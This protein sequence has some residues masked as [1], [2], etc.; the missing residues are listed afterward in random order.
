MKIRIWRA[1]IEDKSQDLIERNFPE[2]L[3]TFDAI[4]MSIPGGAYTT[5]RTYDHKKVIRLD[6]H[7]GRLEE[8][9]RLTHKPVTL[10]QLRLREALRNVIDEYPGDMDL[11]IRVV[12]DLEVALGV[13]YLMVERLKTPPPGAYHSGVRV[14]TCQLHRENPKAKLT[15]SISIADK[16]REQLPTGIEEALM[17]DKAGCI[18]EGLTSNFFA[19]KGGELWTNEE[20][21]LSGIT[22]SLV[23]NEAVR[24]ELPV[25]FISITITEIADL[26]EAF[27]TSSSRGI[28]P[29]KQIDRILIGSGLPV[30]PGQPGPITKRLMDCL[31]D[32]IWNEVEEI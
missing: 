10:E 1:C 25:N 15:A 6:D 11:R 12:L 3:D 23:L 13:I 24:I 8:T 31:E 7:L 20:G 4:T 19:V 5:F 26:E 30:C 16:I 29:V 17:V 14:I 21:V 18:L 2:D 9:A 27:I 22:R 32:R 28:L